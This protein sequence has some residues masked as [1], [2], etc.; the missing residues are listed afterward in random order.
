MS[1]QAPR[2]SW[3]QTTAGLL[4][5]VAALVIAFAILLIALNQ[6]GVIGTRAPA[7]TP[8]VSAAAERATNGDSPPR[9][10]AAGAGID[11]ERQVSF[12]VPRTVSL[13]KSDNLSY[14]IRTVVVEPR[15]SESVRLVFM[16]R[17]HNQQGY[18][19]NFWDDSFRLL[20]HD[21][22]IPA[23]GQLNDVVDARSSSAE[24]AVVF[25]VPKGAVPRAL[26]IQYAGESTELP[27]RLI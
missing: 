20:T 26:Q 15:N 7:A 19:A 1:D 17:M 9:S 3:W 21:G 10:L 13:G 18:Q 22:V 5:G 12:A 11:S 16:V 14:A 2:P 24:R 25:I 4:T 27:I 23:S 8:P 6:V